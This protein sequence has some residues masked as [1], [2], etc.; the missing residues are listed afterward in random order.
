MWEEQGRE[1][2]TLDSSLGTELRV[3]LDHDLSLSWNQVIR[4]TG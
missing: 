3:G 1:T 2:S 4:P